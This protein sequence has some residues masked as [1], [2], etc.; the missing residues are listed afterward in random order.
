M[1]TLDPWSSQIIDY[2]KLFKGF[3][4]ETMKIRDEK[5]KEN[6]LFTRGIIF[7][8]RDF[9]KWWN[10]F[11]NG[12]RVSILTGMM[13][14]GPFHL[15]HKMVIDQLVWYQ[16]LGISITFAIADIEARTVRKI[17]AD[18]VK[19]TVKSYLANA[20]ALGLKPSQDI[21]VQSNRS[22]PYYRL[23]DL[24]S[25]KM[26]FAEVEAIYG[27]MTPGK[28]ISAFTQASDILHKQL[29]DYFGK[30]KILVPVGPDQDPHIR[31]SRDLADRIGFIKPS[32]TYHGFARGLDG[33]KMSSSKPTSYIGLDEPIDVV[34]R[35]VANALTGGRNTLEEQKKLGGQPEKCIIFE[36]YKYHFEDDDAKLS[37]R[38]R[39]CRAGE[40]MCGECKKQLIEKI[41]KWLEK[42]QHKKDKEMARA[43]K[44]VEEN[45]DY[46]F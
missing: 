8:H 38:E 41:T 45:I 40:I 3:G 20:F 10:D 6:K 25:S 16:N 29:P 26:T 17:D 12:K 13:P 27:N 11:R 7:G 4:I 14:S 34:K 33:G 24:L 21:Y 32:A 43:E 2:E 5:L 28:M 37:E 15:G 18:K 23:A 19:E 39:M 36:L 30:H 35:K 1:E 42:H 31:L 22:N 46:P 9:Y 44:F